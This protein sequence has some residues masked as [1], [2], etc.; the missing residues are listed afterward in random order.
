LIVVQALIVTTRDIVG[1]GYLV[2]GMFGMLS[3][4]VYVVKIPRKAKMR[5]KGFVEATAFMYFEH[6]LN[7]PNTTIHETISIIS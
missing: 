2:V 3:W 6:S 5:K 7:L 1:V 4:H